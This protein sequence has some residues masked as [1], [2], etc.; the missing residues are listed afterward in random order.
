MET[1]TIFT[2][3]LNTGRPNLT[4]G[5]NIKNRTWENYL[6][7]FTMQN[8]LFQHCAAYFRASRIWNPPGI[9]PGSSDLDFSAPP[10]EL[11]DIATKFS[12]SH[13]IGFFALGTTT[14]NFKQINTILDNKIQPAEMNAAEHTPAMP[15]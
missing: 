10:T 12:I 3:N 2:Y 1:I 9:E 14:A 6:Q 15:E 5:L 7:R 11:S 13:Y 4:G 8:I